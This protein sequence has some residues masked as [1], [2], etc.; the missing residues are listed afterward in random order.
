MSLEY[1]LPM[2]SGHTTSVG[3]KAETVIFVGKD[4]TGDYLEVD[5]IEY[6]FTGEEF[7]RTSERVPVANGIAYLVYETVALE[8]ATLSGD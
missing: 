5:I 1:L 4:L 3:T 7:L 2:S 6:D 8:R